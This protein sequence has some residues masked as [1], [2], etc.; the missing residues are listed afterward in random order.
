MLKLLEKVIDFCYGIA[1]IL[2][3]SLSIVTYIKLY[4]SDYTYLNN[5]GTNWN[6]GPILSLNTETLTCR[7]GEIELIQDELPGTIDG[8]YCPYSSSIVTG[9]LRSGL[10]RQKRDSL[11]QCSNVQAISP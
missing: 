11:L 1:G 4:T 8:C 3:L 10:C 5:I 7:P 9:K 2:L 6:S